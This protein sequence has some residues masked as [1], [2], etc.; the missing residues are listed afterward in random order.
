MKKREEVV[1]PKN[2]QSEIVMDF[3]IFSFALPFLVIGSARETPKRQ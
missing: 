3:V 2:L 1:V